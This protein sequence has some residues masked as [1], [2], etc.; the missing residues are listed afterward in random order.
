MVKTS[1]KSRLHRQMEKFRMLDNLRHAFIIT[2]REMRDQLRDWRIMLP[3]IMLTLFFPFLANFTTR[4]VL[5]FVE[6]YGANI[7]A[8]RFIPFLLMI[9]GFFPISVSL[10]IALESFAGETERRS[11]EPLLSSPL[12][13]AQ[14]YVGKLFASLL[15]PL[16]AAYFGMVV[17]LIGIYRST[18]W[19]P[20]PMFLVLVCSLTAVQALVMVSGA[21]V[22]STQTTSVRAANLLA[23]FIIIPMAL[24]IQA[25]SIMMLWADYRVL[26]WA[27]LAQV[28]L[29]GLLVRMGISHFNREEL[30][31]RE[32]DTFN[33]RRFW[34]DFRDG[35]IGNAHSVGDWYRREIPQTIRRMVIPI[36]WMTLLLVAGIYMGAAMVKDIG[37]LP[38]A[39]AL[40]RMKII[41]ADILGQFR[42]LGFFSASSVLTIWWHNLRA[43]TIA[44]TLGIFTLG[45]AGALILVLPMAII[46]FFVGLISLT[47]V[48]TLTVLAAVTLPH[49]IFE[50]PALILAGAAILQVGASLVTPYRQQTIGGSLVSSLADWAK[51]MVALVIPLFLGAALLEVFASPGLMVKLLGMG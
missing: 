4:Q 32:I 5:G 13:D 22:I 50:I 28:I 38:D 7:L 12:S 23:S 35:F 27:V 48:S 10:V 30:L 42:K 21:V 33:V 16:M 31:G 11:I 6:K 26:W 43:V 8:E 29:A 24:L 36:F 46:G 44:I 45:V 15:T 19:R 49:G 17:Y 37:P 2:R 34:T 1:Q 14:L 18:T 41:D 47:G 3:V 39:F 51:I 40:D 20:E 25:E 9:V